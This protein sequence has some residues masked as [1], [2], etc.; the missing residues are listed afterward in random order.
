MKSFAKNIE[1][2]RREALSE[3]DKGMAE[4]G[5]LDFTAERRDFIHE[6]EQELK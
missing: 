3:N 6:A 1:L 5:E 4:H 2:V